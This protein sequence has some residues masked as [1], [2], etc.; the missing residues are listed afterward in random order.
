MTESPISADDEARIVAVAMDLARDGNTSELRAFLEHAFPVDARDAQGNTLLM[1]A[2]YH[3]HCETVDVLVAHGADVDLANDRNQ[4]PIA[5]AI[6]KGEEQVVRAL[7]AA[8]ADLD[9]G[10][11]SAREIAA[12]FGRAGLLEP[13]ADRSDN[14]QA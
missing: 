10:S 3:G 12:L 13:P 2:A 7:V 6:F 11:P 4:S 5:G 14:E 8:G 9:A 1:L